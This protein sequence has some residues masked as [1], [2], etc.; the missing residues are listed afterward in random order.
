MASWPTNTPSF[1]SESIKVTDSDPNTK[2]VLTFL[3]FEQYSENFR[4]KA[5]WK[6]EQIIFYNFFRE[7]NSLVKKYVNMRSHMMS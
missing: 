2:F 6:S 5:Y 4:Q 1:K 3:F 7:T